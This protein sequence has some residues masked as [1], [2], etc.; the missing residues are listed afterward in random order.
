MSDPIDRQKAIECFYDSIGG[1]PVEAVQ[2]VKEYADKMMKRIECLPSIKPKC[3]EI[4][5]DGYADGF[6]DGYAQ[7]QKDVQLE[8]KWTPV[9]EN[10]PDT[11]KEVLLTTIAIDRPVI[12][13]MWRDGSWSA[14][15]YDEG[16]DLKADEVVAWMPLP[17]PYEEDK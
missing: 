12:G 14:S 17:K 5:V 15:I 4:T 3:S 1:V 2:Y 8:Q 11:R 9:S 6:S 7:G 16:D 13:R 10:S